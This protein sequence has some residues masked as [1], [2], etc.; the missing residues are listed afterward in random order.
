MP[1]VIAYK[2]L[3][4]DQLEALEREG[5]FA[6][7]PVDLADGYI[8]LSTADQLAGTIDKHF[9]GQ[10]D[11]Q[12]AAVDLEALG[13]AVKWDESRGGQLFPHVYA[14]LTLDIVLAY[15]PLAYE[16]DGSIRLPVAG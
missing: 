14:P 4:A 3:T 2:V 9:A 5:R 6:G 16:P 12:L 11:L 13:E 15:S 8:H 10:D 7:A 1:D